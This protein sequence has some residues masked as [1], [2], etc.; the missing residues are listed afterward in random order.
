MA[1]SMAYGSFWTRDWIQ[2]T[3][4]TYTVVTVMPD[5]LTHCIWILNPLYYSGN[6]GPRFFFLFLFW[7][8]PRMWKFPG[9]GSNP[10]HSSDNAEYRELKGLALWPTQRRCSEDCFL[11]ERNSTEDEQG[12]FNFS[13]L[14]FSE[15]GLIFTSL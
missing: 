6:T 9:Q 15:L 5:P 10:S 13:G 8:H 4:M 14:L 1:T 7:L 3:A 11:W 2:A 12:Q